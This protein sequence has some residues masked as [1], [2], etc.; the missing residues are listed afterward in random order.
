MA[1]IKDSKEQAEVTKTA[2]SLQ[3]AQGSD[4]GRQH[5]KLEMALICSYRFSKKLTLKMI[6]NIHRYLK[7]QDVEVDYN[8]LNFGPLFAKITNPSFISF[9]A[10]SFKIKTKHGYQYELERSKN[11]TED[12]FYLFNI[13]RWKP[14]FKL[15]PL[16]SDP[17]Y[18]ALHW[19]NKDFWIAKYKERSSDKSET[20]LVMNLKTS[21]VAHKLV[22]HELVSEISQIYD[23]RNNKL[24]CSCRR[25]RPEGALQEVGSIIDLASQSVVVE[26]E[27]PFGSTRTYHKG[28]FYWTDSATSSNKSSIIFSKWSVKTSETK[29]IYL[30]MGTT[31]PENFYF[32]MSRIDDFFVE[33]V[34]LVDHGRN[35]GQQK[36]HFVVQYKD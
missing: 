24:T 18:S 28:H 30:N 1:D 10:S 25:K 13:I 2:H 14:N 16:N 7:V 5:P 27:I 8:N 26:K 12:G 23:Y 11:A 9:S 36:V 22:D 17:I 3:G 4:K 20:L 6:L 15:I 29:E 31:L 35:R 33:F 19:I 34:N 32:W 21:D